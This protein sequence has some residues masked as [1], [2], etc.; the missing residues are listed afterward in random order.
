[1]SL[2]AEQLL[3]ETPYG[4]VR[5]LPRA[6]TPL[7]NPWVYDAVGRDMQQLARKGLIEVVRARE[8]PIGDAQLLTE[9]QYRRKR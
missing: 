6:G 7:E 1:M 9:F 4:E 5:S 3:R 8:E 2:I